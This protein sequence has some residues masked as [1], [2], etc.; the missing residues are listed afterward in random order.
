MIEAIG[1]GIISIFPFTTFFWFLSNVFLN[2]P[3]NLTSLLLSFLPASL[4][5]LMLVKLIKKNKIKLKF[6][7]FSILLLA[8]VLSVVILNFIFNWYYPPYF[9]DT[10]TMYDFRAKL[11]VH[12]RDITGIGNSYHGSYPLY[13]SL[14]HTALYILGFSNPKVFY[15]FLLIGFLLVFFSYIKRRSQSLTA[16]LACLFVVSIP[17][18]FFQSRIAYTNFPY[19]IYLSLSG[20]YLANY[21]TDSSL[22]SLTLT[23]AMLSFA[24]WT[25]PANLP[26]FLTSLILI[27]YKFV[28]TKNY[29]HLFIIILFYTLFTLPWGYFKKYH[30]DLSSTQVNS[31]KNVPTIVNDL[32]FMILATAK[33]LFHYFLPSLS[34][35]LA[36]FFLTSLIVQSLTKF[37][38]LFNSISVV[39]LFYS[40]TWFALALASRLRFLPLNSWQALLY[41]AMKR[42]FISLYPLIV[43]TSFT[44]PVVTSSINQLASKIS[45]SEN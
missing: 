29:R 20:L 9:F 25:R 7:S 32:P 43:A 17:W 39:T 41:N 28:R 11:F 27:A 1:I 42:H 14:A 35:G 40:L 3:I 23:S 8:L 18:A 13:T 44:F 21:L 30:L 19:M 38:K 15:S 22:S 6:N 24:A 4:L 37:K 5:S 10:L 26:F 36:L 16:L 31:F 33:A 45:K 34:G 12:H 2:I